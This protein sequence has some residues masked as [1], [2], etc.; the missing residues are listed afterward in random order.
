MAKEMSEE[1]GQIAGDSAFHVIIHGDSVVAAINLKENPL[2]NEQIS[3]IEKFT[4][5]VLKGEAIFEASILLDK[6]INEILNLTET[7]MDTVKGQFA[8]TLT[9]SKEDK[10]A[11][12]KKFIDTTFPPQARNRDK[13]AKLL[14]LMFNSVHIS[15]QS[16][17]QVSF[18]AAS[19]R[20]LADGKKMAEEYIA[21]AKDLYSGNKNG[22]FLP[23]RSGFLRCRRPTRSRCHQPW[24]LPQ[25]CLW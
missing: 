9:S 8:V 20:Y 19:G 5:D 18:S 13:I 14:F 7:Q 24:S 25:G 22:R 1:V 11:I 16:E 15:V 21:M 4:A 3:Q 23:I 10:Y 17:S 2:A 12:K 6:N